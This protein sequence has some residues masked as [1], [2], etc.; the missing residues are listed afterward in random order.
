MFTQHVDYDE[1]QYEL[2][3]DYEINF[4][5]NLHHDYD[6]NGF[7]NKII[8]E[9]NN[10]CQ[11]DAC[12]MA[13]AYTIALSDDPFLEDHYRDLDILGALGARFDFD[14][15]LRIISANL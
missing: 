1:Q 9:I 6:E 2:D 10:S 7:L 13:A 8:K 14:T 5:R 11:I 3:L 4:V 12:K 15:S